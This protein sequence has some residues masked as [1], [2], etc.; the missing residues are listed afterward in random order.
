MLASSLEEAN[1]PTSYLEVVE[2]EM[3]IGSY[4]E[5]QRYGVFQQRLLNS[6]DI[7]CFTGTY[8]KCVTFLLIR[9]KPSGVLM[10]LFSPCLFIQLLP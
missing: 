5:A 2:H 1:L 10:Q 7:K 4:I 8:Q 9:A 6:L 3:S